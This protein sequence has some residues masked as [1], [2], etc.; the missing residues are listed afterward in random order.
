M[1]SIWR[2]LELCAIDRMA[3]QELVEAVRKRAP[4]LPIDLVEQLEERPTHHLQLLLLA[5]RLIR[6]LRQVRVS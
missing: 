5:G 6:A 2:Q 4:D 1:V 3:R